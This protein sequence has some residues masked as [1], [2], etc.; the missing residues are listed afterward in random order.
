MFFGIGNDMGIDL[1][2]ATVLVYLKGKGVILKEPSVVAINRTNNE[3]LAVGEEA[4]QMIGRTPG[5]IT[6]IRPLRNGVI[7]DYD[8]TEKMLK[9]FIRKAC[10]KRRISQPKIII[11]VPCEATGVEQRAVKDAAKN[12][13]AKKV[14]LIEEPLAAAIGAGLDITKASGN[15]VIDIGGGTTDIAVISLGGMVVR[16]SIKVAGDT[17][18]ES[19]IK[20]IRKKHKLMIGERTAE[21]LKINIG[22]AYKKE[23]EETMEIRGRDLVT[24]LPK[25]V[26]VSSSEMRDA[27]KEAVSSIAECAHAVLEKTPPELAADVSDKGIMMTGGGSLLNGLDKFIQE[28]TQVPVYVAEDPVSCVAL[29]TG[30]SLEY[31]DKIDMNDELSLIR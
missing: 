14:S 31:I 15:M 28:V 9:H 11:C 29:G 16:S 25:N 2:T 23:I 30:K 12:A 1:G 6:A 10:G 27:L 7:S 8:V 13:G 24:G 22:S 5:N 21:D 4:R 19:I 26:E 3:V 18:D 17:F 20:Y